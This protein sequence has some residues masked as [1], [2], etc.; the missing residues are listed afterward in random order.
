MLLVGI[1]PRPWVRARRNLSASFPEIVSQIENMG[2][3]NMRTPIH[4]RLDHVHLRE[5]VHPR[6]VGINLRDHLRPEHSE[7]DLRIVISPIIKD[8]DK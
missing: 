8:P 1:S 6:E 4:R 3:R 7:G 2:G 5:F